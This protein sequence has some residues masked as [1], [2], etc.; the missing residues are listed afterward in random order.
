MHFFKAFFFYYSPG[1]EA[2]GFYGPPCLV[3]ASAMSAIGIQSE[4]T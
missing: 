1:Q 3:K 2:L 4:T